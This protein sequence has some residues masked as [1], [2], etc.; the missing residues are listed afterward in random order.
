MA[1]TWQSRQTQICKKS[2]I[3]INIAATMEKDEDEE[4]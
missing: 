4:E 2:M 3:I 1:P